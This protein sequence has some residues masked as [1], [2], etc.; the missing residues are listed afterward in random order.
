MSGCTCV[1]A[2][3]QWSATR[4]C[5]TCGS[6]PT[7][8]QIT[9]VVLLILCAPGTGLVLWRNQS[10]YDSQRKVRYGVGSPGGGDFVGLHLGHYVEVELKSHSGRQSKEQKDHQALV[11]RTGGTYAVIRCEDDAHKLLERLTERPRP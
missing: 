6:H 5:A 11:E 2:H 7:E 8:A 9:P 3:R 10:G 4:P 1:R